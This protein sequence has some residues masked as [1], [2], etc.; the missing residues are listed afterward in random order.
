MLEQRTWLAAR[1]PVQRRVDP[2]SRKEEQNRVSTGLWVYALEDVRPILQPVQELSREI[3][4]LGMLAMGFGL[5]IILAMWWMT[6][7]SWNRARTRL[8]RVLL[9]SLSRRS[10]AAPS[11]LGPTMDVVESAPKTEA[12]DSKN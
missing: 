5:F 3:A 1:S 2:T 4:R 7:R 9:P 11:H 8:N 12:N 6:I 10:V